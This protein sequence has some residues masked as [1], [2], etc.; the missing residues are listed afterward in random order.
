MIIGAPTS[1]R[2]TCGTAHTTSRLHSSV[3]VCIASLWTQQVDCDGTSSAAKR[4]GKTLES[5][6]APRTALRQDGPGCS[7]APLRSKVCWA[8]DA[9]SPT[10]TDDSQGSWEAAGA[11]G[12][13][14]QTGGKRQSRSVTW[15]PPGLLLLPR[16]PSRMRR[17]TP[18]TLSRF[19]SSCGVPSRHLSRLRRRSRR[20]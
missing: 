5:C 2:P 18:S 15:L 3:T 19:A 11:S 17:A 20:R 1:S 10:V 16:R 14:V 12:G 9:R 6:L 13:S 7:P 8:R 4:R